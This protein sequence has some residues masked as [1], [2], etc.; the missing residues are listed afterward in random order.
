[1]NPNCAE[2]T[3]STKPQSHA[4]YN[5]KLCCLSYWAE[6]NNEPRV[7]QAHRGAIKKWVRKTS[8]WRVLSSL[9]FSLRWQFIFAHTKKKC[10]VSLV[11]WRSSFHPRRDRPLSLQHQRRFSLRLGEFKVESAAS[12]RLSTRGRSFAYECP[13][14]ILKNF[15]MG[16]VCVWYENC[17]ASKSA[18]GRTRVLHIGG[19]IIQ[20]ITQAIRQATFN[21]LAEPGVIIELSHAIIAG[22]NPTAIKRKYNLIHFSSKFATLNTLLLENKRSVGD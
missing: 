4:Q 6:E 17:R 21:T 19:N 18:A 9:S 3:C 7:L 5:N 8:A 15:A 14:F 11:K 12:A 1:M 10:T 22:R 16:D 13:C 2:K 20:E